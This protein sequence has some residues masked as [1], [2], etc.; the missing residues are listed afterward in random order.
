MRWKTIAGLVAFAVSPALGPAQESAPT[1]WVRGDRA[2]LELRISPYDSTSVALGDGPVKVCYS[3]PRKL[4][5][6]IFGRLV[7][8]GEPWRFGANEA[9]AIHVP[10]SATIAGVEVG[11]GWH[12]L[13]AIPGEEEWE[14]VV[15]ADVERWGVP[16]N[17]EVRGA[18]IGSGRVPSGTDVGVVELLTMELVSRGPDSADLVVAWDETRLRVP[19][20]VGGGG[21]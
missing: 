4:G 5:R 10:D 6:P 17:D 9:T 8:F 2:D 18:D 20:V 13:V 21:R 15:N 11:P 1:C 7:P 16:I 19:I 12:S 14:I 3:Q